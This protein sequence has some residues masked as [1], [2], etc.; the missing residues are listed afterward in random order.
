LRGYVTGRQPGS[1]S[2]IIKRILSSEA[3]GAVQPDK[4]DRDGWRD[5]VFYLVMLALLVFAAIA[6][7]Y[8]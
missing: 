1:S 3:M 5:Y 4:P 2:G 8:L 7:K 6:S